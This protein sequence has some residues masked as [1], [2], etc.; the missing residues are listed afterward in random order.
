MRLQKVLGIV[1][2]YWVLCDFSFME[3]VRTRKCNKRLHQQLAVCRSNTE[4]SWSMCHWHETS[5]WVGVQSEIGK[6]GNF[7]TG[8]WYLRLGTSW[9]PQYQEGLRGELQRNFLPKKGFLT[10][11]Y[12][13]QASVAALLRIWVSVSSL[14]MWGIAFPGSR[15]EHGQLLEAGRSAA[16]SGGS[17]SPSTEWLCGPFDGLWMLSEMHLYL[18]HSYTHI[19]FFWTCL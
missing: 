3:N 13:Q 11:L 9:N 17:R 18:V 16:V 2:F 15:L 19:H 12:F 6:A 7:I 8:Q 5:V 14:G 10:K 4:F 1:Y